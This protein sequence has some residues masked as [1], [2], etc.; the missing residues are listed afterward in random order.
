MLIY[1][2]SLDGT[3]PALSVLLDELLRCETLERIV[4]DAWRLGQAARCFSQG[5][6]CPKIT[7]WTSLKVPS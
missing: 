2:H 5:L 7:A 4:G 1:F 6:Q 3:L